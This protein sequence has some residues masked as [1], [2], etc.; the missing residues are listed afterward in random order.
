MK[1]CW[2]AYKKLLAYGSRHPLHNAVIHL[3][4]GMG[5]GILLTYPLVGSHPLRWGVV[6]IA[7]AVLGHGYALMKK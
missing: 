4:G 5:L 6:L 1:C 3:V 2:D 7:L